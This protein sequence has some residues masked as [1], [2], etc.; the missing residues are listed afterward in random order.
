MTKLKDS[1]ILFITTSRMTP[2]LEWCRKSVKKFF[3]NSSHLIIDGTNN[4]PNVWFEW[5]DHLKKYEEKYFI[6]IDEDAF[7]IDRSAVEDAILKLESTQSTLAGVHDCYFT[8]RGFNE[9]ALNPFFM[10]GDRQKIL[11]VVQK[12]PNYRNLLFNPKYFASAKYDWP[13]Q[14][15]QQIGQNFEPFYCL[16]W[17]VL[18]ASQKLLY[19]YPNDRSEFVNQYNK[20]PA[21][22]VRVSP[23]SPDMVLHMWY[24]REWNNDIN[25]IRYQKLEKYLTSIF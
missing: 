13:I 15:R 7:V 10:I 19:L 4:W 24:S 22:S 6:M 16:F 21:T 11:D 8:W 3:P 20:L 9:V 14:D 17:A 25:Y 1:D 2:W 12:V 18:E 23:D 5:L